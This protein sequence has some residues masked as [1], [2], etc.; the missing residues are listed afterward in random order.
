ML[1]FRATQKSFGTTP[2]FSIASETLDKGIYW[3]QGENGVGKTTLLRMVAGIVPFKGDILVAGVSQRREPVDYR[4]LV[5]WADAEPLY[6]EFLTGEDLLT[7]YSQILQPDPWQAA[8]L[9]H[10]LGI[11]GW[12]N[13]RL[14]TWSSGMAKKL[15]LLL[16]FLGRP[17]LIALDEP[18]ITL[19]ERGAAG[20]TSLIREYSEIHNT[21]FLLSSHQSVPVETLPQLQKIEIKEQSIRLIN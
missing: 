12:L 17:A 1:E 21:G 4:R 10:R 18:L 6:P 9:I 14:A 20:L 5:G 3:L 19:D 8:G 13:T 11:G 16:A 7:F 2:L 15:F